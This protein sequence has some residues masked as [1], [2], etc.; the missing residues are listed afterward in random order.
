MRAVRFGLIGIAAAAVH[1]GVAVGLVSLINFRPQIANVG[2]YSLAFVVSYLGQGR[3]TFVRSVT[4]STRFWRFAATSI[5]G[6]LLNAAAY[7]TLLHFTSIDYR[8]ALGL[9]LTVV[10]TLTYIVLGRWV[11]DVRASPAA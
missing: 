11:F 2:G 10:A 9:V 8:V 4:G 3:Y 5:S 1:Y 6:F 7:A